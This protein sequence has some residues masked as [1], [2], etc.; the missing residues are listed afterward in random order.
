MSS[1]ADFA[2][3]LGGGGPGGPPPGLGGGAGDPG[4]PPTPGTPPPDDTGAGGEQFTSSLDAL[5]AAESAL[6]AFIQLDPDAADRAVA[7][8]C[9]QNILKLKA[10][11]QQSAQSGDLKSLQRALQGGGGGPAPA[12]AA[13]GGY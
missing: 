9:L 11:N 6:Q 13:G 1:M 12:P 5:D 7:A 3:A 2:A 4:A 8:Q 10:T